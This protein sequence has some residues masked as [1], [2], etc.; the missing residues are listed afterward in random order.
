MP[1]D[2]LSILV[3]VIFSLVVFKEKPSVKAW[4][5]LAILTAGTVLMAIFT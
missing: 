2:K 1:I 5:G 3:T 4:I